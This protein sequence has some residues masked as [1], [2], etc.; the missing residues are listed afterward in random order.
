VPGLDASFDSDNS[1]DRVDEGVE[2]QTGEE[3]FSEAP[4]DC[5]VTCN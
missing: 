3:F 1:I 2:R 4:P 5:R